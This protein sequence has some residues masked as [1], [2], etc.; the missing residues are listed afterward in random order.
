MK[1]IKNSNN[2]VSQ[3]RKDLVSGGWVIIAPKRTQRPFNFKKASVFKRLKGF[4]KNCPFEDPQLSGHEAPSL[5][6]KSAKNKFPIIHILSHRVLNE[7][8]STRPQ[9]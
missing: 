2:K 7:K 3:L 5:V 1:I 9:N 8:C 4:I 6:L